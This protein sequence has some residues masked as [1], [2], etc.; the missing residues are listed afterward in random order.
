M[1]EIGLYGPND[2]FSRDFIS[3]YADAGLFNTLFEATCPGSNYRY[4]EMK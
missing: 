3:Q 1:A 2:A 4:F